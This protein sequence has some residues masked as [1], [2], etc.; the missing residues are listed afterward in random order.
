MQ[1]AAAGLEELI[2]KLVAGGL[3]EGLLGGHKDW[4]RHLR[5]VETMQELVDALSRLEAQIAAMIDGLP[6]GECCCET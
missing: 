2:D 5:C 1:H 3:G 4:K 6:Q